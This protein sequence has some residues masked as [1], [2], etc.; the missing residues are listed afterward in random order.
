MALVGEHET[1]GNWEVEP[2]EVPP[3]IEY[4]ELRNEETENI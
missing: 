1:P 4:V 2:Y 3:K